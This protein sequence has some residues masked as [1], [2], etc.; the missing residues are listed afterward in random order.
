M[1]SHEKSHEKYHE[2]P[3]NSHETSHEKIS[4]IIIYSEHLQNINSPRLR[5]IFPGNSHYS[6]EPWQS[7]NSPDDHLGLGNTGKNRGV[8]GGFMG[9]EKTWTKKIVRFIKAPFK[10][11]WPIYGK[12][13]FWYVG[14]TTVCFVRSIFFSWSNPEI[15]IWI[16]LA[17]L[18]YPFLWTKV[19]TNDFLGDHLVRKCYLVLMEW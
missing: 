16:S 9:L 1:N 19:M 5:I 17:N 10:K 14:N 2:F 15:V 7:A 18:V 3:W 13:N 4:V 12:A 6:K 8:Y 11:R